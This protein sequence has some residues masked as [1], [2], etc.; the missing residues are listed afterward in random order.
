[1]KL[2]G[3]FAEVSEKEKKKEMKEKNLLFPE[4]SR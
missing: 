2:E 4:V 3:T 1:M